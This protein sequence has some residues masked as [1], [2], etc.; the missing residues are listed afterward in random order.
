MKP[1]S[2]FFCLLCCAAVALPWTVQAQVPVS[3]ATPQPPSSTKP[4]VAD[5]AEAKRA[6]QALDDFI[7]AYQNGNV[8]EIRQQLDPAM[9]GYQ[10]FLDG[11]TQDQ[12]RFTQIRLHLLDTQTLVGPDVAIV[13]TRWEKRFLS[14]TALQ[15][16]MYSG[17]SQF[18]LH[19]SQEG[20]RVAAIGGD[21]PFSSQSGV[22]GRINLTQP[23]SALAPFIRIELIDPD[24]AG[25][26]Q[27][28]VE[29]LCSPTPCIPNTVYLPETTPGRFVLTTAAS[30]G[31][32]TVRY[33]DNNPGGGRPPS[34]LSR[35]LQIAP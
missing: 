7:R 29:L 8:A 11:I 31:T 2:S 5:L 27:T 16:G 12:R 4:A 20:W 1:S 19:K 24:L 3:Q 25:S 21:D 35:S 26:H 6:Q 15:P 34:L 32:M 33:I 9:L 18:L 23:P 10:R 22:L 17:Q 14:S 30:A 28:A 13:Q